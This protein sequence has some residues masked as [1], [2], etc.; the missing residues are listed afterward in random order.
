MTVFHSGKNIRRNIIQCSLFAVLK[1]CI[2]PGN[3][4]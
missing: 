2:N 3:A 4:L 1:T